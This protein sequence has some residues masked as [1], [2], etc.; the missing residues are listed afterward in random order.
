MPA[1]IIVS[2]GVGTLGELRSTGTMR[3]ILMAQQKKRIECFRAASDT[4]LSSRVFN[5]S[6][7]IFMSSLAD[8]QALEFDH[9]EG[10]TAEQDRFFMR[11][12][13]HGLH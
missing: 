10:M 9:S 6:R 1:V 13:N 8:A 7:V 4:G 5:S 2:G 12:F 11:Y 3:D